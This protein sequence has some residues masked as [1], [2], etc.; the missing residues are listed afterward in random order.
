M[1]LGIAGKLPPRGQFVTLMIERKSES[2]EDRQT[3]RFTE[4]RGVEREGKHF[5]WLEV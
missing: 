1:V 5:S 4:V 3:W 2:K